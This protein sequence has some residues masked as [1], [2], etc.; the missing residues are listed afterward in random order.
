MGGLWVKTFF[1]W[2][3]DVI[4]WKSCVMD[5]KLKSFNSTYSFEDNKCFN[6]DAKAMCIENG[7]RCDIEVDGFYIEV[8]MNVIYAVLWYQLGKRTA[9]FLEEL[10]MSD[11]RVLLNQPENFK[12]QT[13]PEIWREI[14]ERY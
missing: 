9:K 1:I 14:K 7:G 12:H 8:A 11:W 2:F 6:K 5:D 13:K 4:T 3:V 10:P